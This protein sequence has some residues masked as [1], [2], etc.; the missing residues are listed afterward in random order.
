MQGFAQRLAEEKGK[1]GMACYNVFF[2]ILF[3]NDLD[4]SRQVRNLK[5]NDK[6]FKFKEHVLTET[7]VIFS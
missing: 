1:A 4:I 3:P 7:S 6:T 5:K 2:T